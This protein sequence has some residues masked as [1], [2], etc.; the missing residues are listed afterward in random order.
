MANVRPAVAPR[1]RSA[2][3][4]HRA[5]QQCH[6]RKKP[7]IAGEL[8]EHLVQVTLVLCN[9]SNP[10]PFGGKLFPVAVSQLL[11]RDTGRQFGKDLVLD[12][13]AEPKQSRGT[14]ILSRNVDPR[15]NGEPKS[16][17]AGCAL[18]RSGDRKAGLAQNQSI[19]ETSI[20]RAQQ[21]GVYD[22]MRS[23]LQAQPRLAG[24]GA[25]LAIERV[26]S[27]DGAYLDQPG[28]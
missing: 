26:A 10:Y 9:G 2:G 16:N 13:R 28:S 3:D 5:Q 22:D 17:L 1:Q 19:A 14:E 23:R 7:E 18:D 4:A 11:G 27:L 6:E 12:P 24:P 8:R 25:D 21:R 20:Q 15:P